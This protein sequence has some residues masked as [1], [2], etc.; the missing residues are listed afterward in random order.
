MGT[1]PETMD[2]SLPQDIPGADE[3]EI[4]ISRDFTYFVRAIRN[5][6]T[7][8]DAYVK[9]KQEKEWSSHPIIASLNPLFPR[10]L[11]ELPEDMQ[12]YY[13][14]DGSPPLIHNHYVANIHCYYH[15][16]ILI[17]H[18]P[19]LMASSFTNGT[20]WKEHM[21]MSY[22]SAKSIC[23]VQEALLQ[24]YG[25]N[26]FLY[27]QR[28]MQPSLSGRYYADIDRNQFCHLLYPDVH[29]SASSAFSLIT[30]H[31]SFPSNA[32]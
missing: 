8:S 17:L 2:F 19:Q 1:D 30:S 32:F 21:S 5:V 23:R 14:P 24:T 10:W 28:G 3:D 6:R 15:L 7:I 4:Q 31:S 13:P 18:R 22:A 11:D 29:A 9:V 16:S 25:I 26:A 20:S 27:M 12:I